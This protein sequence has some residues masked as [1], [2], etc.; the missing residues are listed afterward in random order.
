MHVTVSHGSDFC[1]VDI[2][3]VHQMRALGEELRGLKA[4]AMGERLPLTRL[5][6]TAG[7]TGQSITPDQARQLA[8]WLRRAAGSRRMRRA[9]GAL[10]SQLSIAAATAAAAGE[11][12]TWTVATAEPVTR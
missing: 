9:H 7:E 8:G 2:V 5:L 3:P 12:W 6:D 1:G 11:P 4:L 10:A